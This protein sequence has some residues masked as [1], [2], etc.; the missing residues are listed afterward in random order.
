MANIE[1]RP[2]KPTGTASAVPIVQGRLRLC[3]HTTLT[4]TKM[5]ALRFSV[6]GV[7]LPLLAPPFS[8]TGEYGAIVFE[9]DHRSQAGAGKRVSHHREGVPPDEERVMTQ[10]RRQVPQ[11]RPALGTPAQ[12]L[13]V[14]RRQVLAAHYGRRSI[15]M[16]H[17]V[18]HDET[19]IAEIAGHRRSGV[20]RRVL[21]VR[22]IDV[23]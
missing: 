2:G 17:I 11:L 5:R 1:P 3:A 14:F 20:R 6:R 8:I 21:D 12:E 13:D 19:S 16:R 15:V 9:P 4:E 7:G 23:P 10:R 18:V 22:P